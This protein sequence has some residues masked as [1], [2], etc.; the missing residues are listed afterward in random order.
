ME[1]C[2]DTVNI[3]ENP[4]SVERKM[5]KTLYKCLSDFLEFVIFKVCLVGSNN[6]L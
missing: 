3:G 4:E 6:Y 2:L 1:L 5:K